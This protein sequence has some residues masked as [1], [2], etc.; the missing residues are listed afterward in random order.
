[1]AP[2]FDAID[3][4]Y[5]QLHERALAVFAADERVVRVDV[6]GS[7]ATDTADAWSDLDLKVIV[8]DADVG[9][10]VE[11]WR[12]WLAAI[13][14]TV[15]A[16]RPLA[17]FIIN[18]VTPDGLTFDVSVWAQSAPEWAMP[19]GLQVGFLAG[20][21]YHDYP[22][23][24]EYAVKEQLRGMAGP[25]I[26]FLKR[27]QHI[28]HLMGIGHTLSLLIAVLLAETETPIDGRRPADMLNTE[29]R[30]VVANLPS[31]QPTLESLLTYELSIAEEVITRGRNLFT[32]FDLSW[33]T[34]LEAVALSNVRT[35]LRLSPPWL[36]E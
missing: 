4:R 21:R 28:T 29:Q 15:F 14:P 8:R 19:T 16:E 23:A 20:Q 3:P 17:P 13:T 33:P 2:G 31:V 26:R 12:T 10:V 30:W 9:A 32:K 22:T 36:R 27:G 6:H 7:V 1:M 35:H 25:L 11:E 18:S 34:E 24:V 5:T